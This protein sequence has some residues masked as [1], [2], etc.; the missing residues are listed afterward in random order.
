MSQYRLDL[1]P[2]I[3]PL[4]RVDESGEPVEVFPRELPISEGLM[5]AIS[6]WADRYRVAMSW[7]DPHSRGFKS[8]DAFAAFV[9]EG[10]DLAEALSFELGSDTIVD[11]S[12]GSQRFVRMTHPRIEHYRVF[13]DWGCESP[14]WNGNPDSDPYNLPLEL[15][16][17][18]D[19]LAKN[20]KIWNDK[21]Q[22]TLNW[23]DPR[24][25]GFFT[26]AESREFRREGEHLAMRL[27]DELDVESTV[28]FEYEE[29][30]YIRDV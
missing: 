24:D 2:G 25:S 28:S 14:V 12:I 16:P 1:I 10:R 18:S 3:F 22:A 27:Q 23:E 17:I 26:L 19:D 29:T 6:N 13:P 15:L 7:P 4:V 5:N 20:F 9:R 21:F 11:T 30:V 8:D